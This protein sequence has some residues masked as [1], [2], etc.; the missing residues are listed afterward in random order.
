MKLTGGALIVAGIAG[1]GFAIYKGWIKLPDLGGILG[2]ILPGDVGRGAMEVPGIP[3]AIGGATYNVFSP[4]TQTL[5]ERAIDVAPRI[6]AEEGIPL[7]IAF[8]KAVAQ[9]AAEDVHTGAFGTGFL[10]N[11]FPP[12]AGYTIGAGLGAVDRWNKYLEGLPPLD[13]TSARQEEYERRSTWM[14]RHPVES[15]IGFPAQVIHELTKPEGA[16]SAPLMSLHKV[17]AASLGSLIF[18]SPK[19]KPTP[20]MQTGTFYNIGAAELTPVETAPTV[21]QVMPT[22]LQD[23]ISSVAAAITAQH[24][25]SAPEPATVATGGIGAFIAAQME[26]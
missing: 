5:Q 2:A 19:P 25:E 4:S 7:D 9:E 26:G 6:A 13:K 22:S 3:G 16:P 18:G 8:H 17:F 11:L 24:I 21:T 20:Q 14:Y 15:T 12:F 1:L 23:K 10:G